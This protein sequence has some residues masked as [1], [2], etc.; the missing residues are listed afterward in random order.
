MWV[1][2][3]PVRACPIIPLLRGGRV[4]KGR[5][6]GVFAV[7]AISSPRYLRVFSEVFRKSKN[8]FRGNASIFRKKRG[9]YRRV[10]A[11]SQVHLLV[12]ITV[13]LG[14]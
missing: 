12:M 13:S 3:S 10:F 11:E 7:W 5:F 8:A 9:I 6:Y 4:E 2:I 14:I 1:Y